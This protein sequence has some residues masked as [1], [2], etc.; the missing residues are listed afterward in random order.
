MFKHKRMFMSVKTI[1]VTTEAYEAL[2]KDKR[3]DESFSELL[4]RTHKS[5][6]K[7]EDIMKFV[8]AWDGM[9]DETEEKLKTSINI[10]RGRAG[11]RR[12][13][14]LIKHFR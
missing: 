10:I 5:K 6:S 2:A 11:K 3:K 14:E 9:S 8:G 4:L 1:T 13:K 7:V 12:R